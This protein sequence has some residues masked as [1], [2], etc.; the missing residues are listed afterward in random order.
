MFQKGDRVLV[1]V[2]GGRRAVLRVWKAL[3]KG[4]QLCTEEGYRALEEGAAE[5]PLV[6]F[7]SRDVVGMADDLA[8][9]ALATWLTEARVGV[10]V[11]EG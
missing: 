3:R 6:G 10:K 9:T 11:E 1:E 7:P 4:Y 5:I 2:F 8:D